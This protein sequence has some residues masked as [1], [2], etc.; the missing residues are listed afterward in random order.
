MMARVPRV[1]S[2][3]PVK[4]TAIAARVED[5]PWHQGSM[6]QG[7]KQQE[8]SGY[9]RGLTPRLSLPGELLHPLAIDLG[10]VDIAVRIDADGVRQRELPGAGTGG[11]EALDGLALGVKDGDVM[12]AAVGD[13][14]A[15]VP[16]RE[17]AE[18][19][20]PFFPL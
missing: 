19:G 4:A 7:Q 12:R 18:W 20:A 3:E 11:A 14:E 9:R 17:E 15:A 6:N 13:E 2:S 1:A 10:D 8:G 16:G 5:N